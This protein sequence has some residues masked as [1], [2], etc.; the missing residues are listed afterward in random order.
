MSEPLGI[1]CSVTSSAL[2]RND[3]EK[4]R[5]GVVIKIGSRYSLYIGVG[6]LRRIMQMILGLFV[7]LLYNFCCL[8]RLTYCGRLV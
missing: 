8:G 6:N 1:G 3:D 2:K 7:C 5:A 4:A